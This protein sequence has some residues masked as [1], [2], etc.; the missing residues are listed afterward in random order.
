MK[1]KALLRR[2]WQKPLTALNERYKEE[3]EF[4][5]KLKAKRKKGFRKERL[6]QAYK[7]GKAKA[8]SMGKSK[9]G[10]D[11]MSKDL[12]GGIL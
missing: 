9:K 3:K 11:L 10:K 8:R 6:N 12:G 5:R 2:A 4:N 7:E 1:F